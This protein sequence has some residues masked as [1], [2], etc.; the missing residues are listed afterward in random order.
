M[1]DAQD[2]SQDGG[3][4][5]S[6]EAKYLEAA[7]L[8]FVATSGGYVSLELGEKKYLRVHFYRAFPA[9]EPVAFVCI[10]DDE[11]KEIGILESLEGLGPEAAALVRGE[12]ERRYYTPTI[13]KVLSLKE[14]FGYTYWEV[15][16]DFG[17]RRFTVQS[18]GNNALQRE[19][20]SVILVDVDGNRF[21]LPDPSTLERK[22]LRVLEALL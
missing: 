12:L 21:E 13:Q 1:S 2:R 19:G 17:N 11:G 18:S 16:T 6:I 7:S 20:L 9:T 10:R 15:E 5:D 8:H 22:Q 3:A 4:V 14:E